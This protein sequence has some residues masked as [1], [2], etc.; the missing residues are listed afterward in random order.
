MRVLAV[1]LAVLFSCALAWRYRP[2]LR[3]WLGG[4]DS[5]QLAPADRVFVARFRWESHARSAFRR[6]GVD[7]PGQ[8]LF[9]RAFKREGELELWAAAAGKTFVRVMEFP[10]LKASGAPGPKR[11]E[12]DRQVPEG[13]YVVDRLNPASAYHL[14]MGLNYPNGSDQ[15]RSDPAAPGCDI[16][17]HGGSVSVGCM[18]LGDDAI[19]ELFLIVSDAKARGFSTVPLHIF[20]GRMSGAEWERFRSLELESRPELGPF[21]QELQPIYDY[22]ERNRRPPE[23]G[24]GPS[25]EYYL[26]EG[27]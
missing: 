2:V 20:P 16:F 15:I 19:E 12:G 10:I 9:L 13:C 5:Q 24:T 3:L 26:S 25:G 8:R 14:S 6:A 21:W 18:P 7:Y 22:F 4:A 27:K 23:V 17:I 1:I 11:R